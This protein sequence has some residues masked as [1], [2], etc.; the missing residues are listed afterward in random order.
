MR[1]M[2]EKDEREWKEKVKEGTGEGSHAPTVGPSTVGLRSSIVCKSVFFAS[3]QCVCVCICT[4]TTE[5]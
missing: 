1:E 5:K 2:K 3:R 4:S